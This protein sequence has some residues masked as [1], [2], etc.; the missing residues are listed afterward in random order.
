MA[1][2]DVDDEGCGGFVKSRDLLQVSGICNL[3]ACGE[4]YSF[5]HDFSHGQME[6]RGR[7][8][9][10]Q[11]DYSWW[12]QAERLVLSLTEA[13]RAR[14]TPASEGERSSHLL[15]ILNRLRGKTRAQ[16][17][18]AAAGQ[19]LSFSLA[20]EARPVPSCVFP[21][22]FALVVGIGS[23]GFGN[24]CLGA[25]GGNVL[26]FTYQHYQHQHNYRHHHCRN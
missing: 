17:L 8:R 9:C 19:V 18:R 21:F 12:G 22:I 7:E 2:D 3:Y 20:G 11:L 10:E 26:R 24:I 25:Y 23:G 14:W 1:L 16:N 4:E 6:E 15:G 5:R 13:E